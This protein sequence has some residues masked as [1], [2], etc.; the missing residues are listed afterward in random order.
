MKMSD[1]RKETTPVIPE[2]SKPVFTEETILYLDGASGIS[3]DMFAA[4]MIDLGADQIALQRALDSIPDRRFRVRI[5][6]VKK[7]A[8]DCCDFHVLLDA[9]LDN[10]DA[11][12]EYLFG[13][14]TA[15]SEHVH[16][17]E[18]AAEHAA[19]THVHHAH[20]TLK[21]VRGIL[22]ACD[23]TDRARALA[24]SIFVILAEAEAKA[25]GTSVEE[26]HFHEVGALDSIVDI[27]TAAV[28]FDSL[29]VRRVA[30]PS[31]SE[32]SG[33]VR[34]AH[35]ILPIPVPAV[36]NIA[37]AGGLRISIDPDMKG[38]FITP[39]GAAIAA[40][41]MTD[42][43]LPESFRIE[44]IGLGAG[45]RNYERPNYLRAMLI[46]CPE[47]RNNSDVIWKLETDIDDCTGEIL[48]YVLER[49][50]ECGAK[51]A[52]YIPVYMK[53]NRPAWQLQVICTE[54]V[55]PDMENII[56]SETTSIGIRRVRMERTVQ[57][58]VIR[59]VETP[60]GTA[61]VKVCRYRGITRYFPEY[62][63]VR[64]IARRE[65]I[66]FADV[67][68]MVSEQAEKME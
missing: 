45:K 65:N 58:R 32:G 36:S 52:H 33:T 6:R 31:L 38:E 26:V 56:F 8:I 61:E 39:T 14:G 12:M 43:E 63:S 10:H 37:A 54:D 42:R 23:M 11:D 5:G 57:E 41:L 1:C 64:E 16:H 3:G 2:D 27:I 34:C 68:R 55:I 66:P 13:K 67:F 35:G 44:K 30:V 4:A 48:G 22:A 29:G 28:C 50:L 15:K 18:H 51:D 20:R 7:Q 62:E 24:D 49:L 25:H 46:T 60:C 21:D 40:A 47:T 19:H 17:H 9:E 53:K 59:K